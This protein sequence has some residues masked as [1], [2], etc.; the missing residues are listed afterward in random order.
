MCNILFYTLWRS[1]FRSRHVFT[2]AGSNWFA[3]V[4]LFYLKL[5]TKTL[6][7]RSHDYK[8]IKDL[9]RELNTGS[10][11]L[12]WKRWQNLNAIYDTIR[13]TR[14]AYLLRVLV[15]WNWP[16]YRFDTG[17]SGKSAHPRDTVSHL[18]SPLWFCKTN[19]RWKLK[20]RVTSPNFSSY[21]KYDWGNSRIL[22]YFI[23]WVHCY[24]SL[25]MGKLKEHVI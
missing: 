21:G 16:R 5:T 24:N 23:N 10:M 8:P 19:L 25:K 13:S 3:T 15:V 14:F 20:T 7:S 22:I 11:S 4:F 9:N 12:D 6:T 17:Y 2:Q 18:S 1:A